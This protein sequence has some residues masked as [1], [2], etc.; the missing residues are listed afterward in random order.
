MK[1]NVICPKLD[2]FANKVIALI[3][4]GMMV[5]MFH[6]M[7]KQVDYNILDDSKRADKMF[8]IIENMRQKTQDN[9]VNNFDYW[10]TLDV[11]DSHS[12][13]EADIQNTNTKLLYTLKKKYPFIDWHVFITAGNKEPVAGPNNS[14]RQRL[15][16]SANYI[17]VNCFVIPTNEAQVEY[18]DR[19][20]RRWK[21][22]VK[23]T[24]F[25]GD[26]NSGIDD[27]QTRVEKD[28]VLAGQV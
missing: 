24:K 22:L 14:P 20:L 2:L 13:F 1:A 21:E 27:I 12:D 9:C 17:N 5:T 16:S 4:K 26:L 8:T 18:S 23:Q 11:Q 3:S 6:D 15:I 7:L 28:A 10:M 25:T 19:K